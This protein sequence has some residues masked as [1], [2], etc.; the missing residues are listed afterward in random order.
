M[1][2]ATKV[3]LSIRQGKPALDNRFKIKARK[4]TPDK[5]E[6]LY[7]KIIHEEKS[8]EKEI[9]GLHRIVKYRTNTFVGTI[10]SSLK[11]QASKNVLFFIHG[12]HPFKKELHIHL[13]D[14]LVKYYSHSANQKGFGSII[15]FSW[16]NMGLQWKEDDEALNIGKTLATRYGDIFTGIKDVCEDE[17]GKF[18]LMCQSFGHHVLNGLVNHLKTSTPCFRKVFLL[19]A[20]I[21]NQSLNS[22]PQV[23]IHVPNRIGYNGRY[24]HYN[25]TPL[26]FLSKEIHVFY[27]LYDVILTASKKSFLKKYERL[28]KTGPKGGKVNSKFKIHKYK[29]YQDGMY[30]GAKVETKGLLNILKKILG[31]RRN[32]YNKRHQYF[33]TNCK[34]REIINSEIK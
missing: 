15:F 26:Q 10:R 4:R 9:G 30:L 17:G 1:S 11:K 31:K 24:T 32:D 20:D 13:L 27:D 8:D 21:P 6:N 29:D 34:V 16:P 33:Y 5:D 7:Y 14:E 23:G 18:Y 3:F 2:S 12:Y 22:S 19:A 25:L 28:G